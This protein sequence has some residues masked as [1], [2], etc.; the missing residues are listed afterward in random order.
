MTLMKTFLGA[1]ATL[2]LSAGFAAADPAIIF[3]L[4]GKFDKSFNE[5]A[6]NGA[7]RWKA[8]T[9]GTYKELEMQ[10]EAQREQALRRLAESGANPVVMTGFAF[11]DVLG[12]VAPDFPDTKFVII[13]VDWLDF[14]NVRQISFAEHEGSY[15]VGM[16]AAMASKTGTVGFIGGMDVPLIR[17]FACGYV[18]GVKAA[19]PDATIIQNMTGSTPAAWNDPVKGGEIAKAQKS[20]GADVIYAAAGGTG[21]GVLQAAADEGILSIG[22]DSN[23]NHLHPGQVLT[24]MLKRVDNAVYEAFKAGTEIEG[25]VQVMDLASGGVGYALDDNN[26]AL[27]S[28]EMKTAVDD[29]AAKITSGEIAVHDYMTDDSCPVN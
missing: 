5:A 1:A 27:V 29:A 17:K 18:Q 10:S 7:E 9:G 3:D 14:P 6:Y 16:M 13:D 8:E 15:L 28:D 4:G 19:N 21:I 25:G 26:A 11:G 24:S 20:Q 2:A 12:Q 22:V 23:Q